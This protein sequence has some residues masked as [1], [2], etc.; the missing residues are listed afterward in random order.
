MVEDK[1]IVT[2][3]ETDAEGRVVFDAEQQKTVAQAYCQNPGRT[4]L[5]YPG[6]SVQ[7]NLAT[8][9]PS[10]TKDQKL[11]HAMSAADFSA[12]VHP[13]RT[14][15]GLNDEIRHARKTLDSSS[16]ADLISK[17]KR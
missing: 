11:L 7:I 6:H 3:G 8:E 2:S 16:D 1:Q 4:W 10:W 15:D 13:H 12:D 5:M 9:D 14:S 17:L